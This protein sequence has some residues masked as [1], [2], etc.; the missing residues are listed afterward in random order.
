M[1]DFKLTPAREKELEKLAK[2]LPDNDFKKRYGKDWKSVKIAT[3]MNMLKKKYGF[4]EDKMKFKDLREK[5]KSKFPTSLVA[6]AVKIALDMGGNMTG[7]YKKI[8]KMKR[9]LGDDPAVKDALRLANENVKKPETAS[10]KE[11][12]E[13]E[14]NSGIFYSTKLDK[15]K[16]AIGL[17][18]K[19]RAAKVRAIAKKYKLKTSEA[20]SNLYRPAKHAP[21]LAGL[22]DITI[23]GPPGV[24]N[25]AL[26]EVPPHPA[27]AKLDK[28]FKDKPLYYKESL[29]EAYS[30]NL[31]DREIDAQFKKFSK[32]EEF[33]GDLDKARAEMKQDYSPANSARPKAWNS[34]SYPVRDGDY[35]FAFISKNEKKNMKFNEQM[36]D[37][38]KDALKE[39]NRQNKAI[40]AP[41]VR[42][43]LWDKASEM[44]SKLP[45]DLGAGDTM[46]REEIWMSIGHMLGMNEDVKEMRDAM[47]TRAGIK[48]G[49]RARAPKYESKVRET[50]E[51]KFRSFRVNIKDLAE[52]A[53]FE[54]VD[55]D[56]KRRDTVIAL[57]KKFKLKVKE[58]KKGSLSNID[59]E[60]SN[61]NV[62]KFMQ[63]LPQD[64]L[65]GVQKEATSISM[66]D[67][68]R[69]HGREL[70]KVVRTGNLELSDRAEEDL[71]NWA[72]DNGEVMTDDPD[73]FIQWLDDNIDDI[74]KGR[75]R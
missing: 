9:G 56:K 66:K 41:Q 73:E 42:D 29:N 36:N 53:G 30:K 64:A 14:E 1:A 54:F 17:L 75:I 59:V 5:Y 18:D 58:R 4:K 48:V 38:L 60:G 43:L 37:M 51:S 33:F 34:L 28:Q 20:P 50:K 32:P 44:V 19:K 35:Y 24:V 69:K 71:V 25:K 49:R 72:Y 63:N 45:R 2:D 55:M 39:I 40:R 12:V 6:A 46:T 23:M 3:A 52:A 47:K 67:I 27:V 62:A 16:F 68:M 74:V 8:E 7:A 22:V 10:Q 11:V 57:A 65:E 70:K 26:K 13:V 31:S 61:A 15:G 21:K